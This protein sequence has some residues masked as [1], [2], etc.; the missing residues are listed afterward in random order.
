MRLAADAAHQFGGIELDRSKPLSFRL[1]GHKISGFAGDT[2]LSALLAAGIDTF[3]TFAGTSIGLTPRFAPLIAAKGGS[4]LPMERAPAIDGAELTTIGTR[5]GLAMSHPRSLRQ[6]LDDLPDPPWFRTKPDETRSVDLLVVGGGVTGLAAADA[7]VEAGHTVLLAERRP[8]LGGDAR[9]FGAVGDDETPEDL[10][11]RLATLLASNQKATVLTRAE[12]F[13]LTGGSALLHVIDASGPVPQGRVMAVSA[14]HVLLATGAT[15]RLPIFPGNRRPAVTTAID[16]YHLA[17]RYGVVRGNT[18][19][20]ATQS[21]YG[22][23]LALRLHDAGVKIGRIIDVRI[24]PQSRFVDFAKASGLTLASGQVPLSATETHFVFAPAVG[25]GASAAFESDQLIVSGNWQP[26]LEL[27][28]QMG[29]GVRWS[30]EHSAL[31]AHDR[32]EQTALAGSAAGYRSMRACVES[33]RAAVATL[34]GKSAESIEDAEPGTHLETPDAPPHIIAVGGDVPAFFDTGRSFAMQPIPK[35]HAAA[36]HRVHALTLADVAAS[37]ELG[38]IAPA[39]A[40]GIAEE[41]GAPGGD[42]QP[43]GWAPTAPP[44]KAEL[45]PYFAHRFGN[46]PRRLHLIVDA[47]RQF[48]VGT[49]VYSN[50]SPRD[51]EHAIGVVIDTAP[52]GGIALVAKAAVRLDRF[53]VEMADGPSPARIK[54]D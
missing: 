34:F 20:V 47:K 15:Q 36:S 5:R 21:N 43:S 6:V 49:L 16:A 7:A 48:P 45:P 9:Y 26:D 12:V 8:W 13:A 52:V 22:Y 46:T 38:L 41:R 19:L 24:H 30:T 27:W 37:V 14:K 40:G 23:R 54:R 25:A 33:G 18:A 3:G 53:I 28:M 51:P 29:G 10:T 17:K 4:A 32:V 39:D 50:Q 42:L 35:A 11:T 44:D 31:V 2:V 1:D